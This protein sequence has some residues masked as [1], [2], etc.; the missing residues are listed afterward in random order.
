MLAVQPLINPLY[1]GHTAD[2]LLSVLVDP[3]PRTGHQVARDVFFT[4]GGGQ[5][6]APAPEADPLFEKKWRAFLHE[7]F[8]AGS[9]QAGV[10]LAFTGATLTA[11]ATGGALSADNLE[12]TFLQDQSV[13][14][15]RFADNAWLQEMPDFMTKLTWDNAAVISPAMSK[16]LGIVHGDLVELQY[17]GRSLEAASTCCRARPGIRWPSRSATG[18]TTPGAWARTPASTPTS[19]APGTDCTAG[20]AS[21]CARRASSTAWPPRQDHHAIDKVGAA[22]IQK[23]VPGPGAQGHLRAVRQ[24]APSSS[25]ASGIQ[26]PAADLALEGWESRATSG[27]WRST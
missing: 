20:K 21:S 9:T 4:L 24:R 3:T 13:Y 12:I 19:C 16:E 17:K 6:P 7:G 25:T 2:E 8:L 10:A 22:E 1:A 23:R 15:G 18:A 27:G 11:P 14:D 26:Q 5:A